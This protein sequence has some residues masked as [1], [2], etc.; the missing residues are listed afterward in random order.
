MAESI[1]L[2]SLRLLL[3]ARRDADLQP[4]AALNA[5]PL[6]MEYFPAC[7]NPTRW[8]EQHP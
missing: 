7:L 2:E 4:F 3:R 1:E 6:V 8:L 5:D